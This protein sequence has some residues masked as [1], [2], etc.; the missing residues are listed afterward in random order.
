[1]LGADFPG[2]YP[3]EDTGALAALLR[4][5]ED[6]PAYLDELGRHGARLAPRFRPEREQAAW[7]DLLREMPGPA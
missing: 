5:A 1:M 7:A 2:Y 6:E 4:R 3:V